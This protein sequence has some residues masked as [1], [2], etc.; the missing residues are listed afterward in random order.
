[1][2]HLVAPGLA[3][4]GVAGVYAVGWHQ[5]QRAGR[6]PLLPMRGA[7]EMAVAGIHR[8]DGKRRV[9][10]G[11]VTGPA[12]TGAAAFHMRE[13]RVAPQRGVGAGHHK[14]LDFTGSVTGAAYPYSFYRWL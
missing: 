8:T 2:Q 5:H 4:L 3:W 13:C 14:V 11:L 7:A 12:M 10:V 1:M 6:Q 9:A